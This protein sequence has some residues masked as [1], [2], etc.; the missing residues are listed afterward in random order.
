MLNFIKKH[1][2]KIWSALWAFAF[3]AVSL[4]VTVS[5]GGL[6]TFLPGDLDALAAGIANVAQSIASFAIM[7]APVALPLFAVFVIIWIIKGI[8][9]RR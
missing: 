1:V 2:A 7:I 6:V 3:T 8:A 5:T 4:W 9:N